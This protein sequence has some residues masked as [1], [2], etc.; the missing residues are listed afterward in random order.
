MAVVV[1][2]VPDSSCGLP[3][4]ISPLGFVCIGLAAGTGTRGEAVMQLLAT[5]LW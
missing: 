3:W 4:R 5:W 2:C 1:L